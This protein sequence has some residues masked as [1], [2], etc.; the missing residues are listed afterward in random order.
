MR[1][2]VGGRI[3]RCTPAGRPSVQRI[4]L[5]PTLNRRAAET[6]NLAENWHWTRV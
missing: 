2:T 5:R 3:M 1:P 6:S 4:R